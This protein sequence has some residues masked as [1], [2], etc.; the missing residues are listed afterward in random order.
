MASSPI[1]A[2]PS[3]KYSNSECMNVC[4]LFCI[5]Y[6]IMAYLFLSVP[7]LYVPEGHNERY[8]P[9]LLFMNVHITKPIGMHIAGGM[10]WHALQLSPQSRNTTLRSPVGISPER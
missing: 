6:F 2:I 4:I 10:Y 8:T 7:S 9:T 1:T 5:E 3:V